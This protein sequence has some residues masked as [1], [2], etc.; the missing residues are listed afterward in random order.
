MAPE[1]TQLALSADGRFVAYATQVADPEHDTSIFIL[2]LADLADGSQRELMRAAWLDQLRRIP[3]ESDWSALLDIGAGVQL[4]RIDRQGG[5]TPLLVHPHPLLVGQADRALPSV[6]H[7]APRRVGVLGYDWS[8]DGHWLWY[9]VLKESD[10]K[11]QVI[12]D[13]AVTALRGR[14]RSRA[15]ATIEFHLRSRNG[16]DRLVMSRPTSD[17]MAFYYG[18]NVSWADDEIRYRIENADLEGRPSFETMVWTMSASQARSVSSQAEDP[19]IWLLRGPRGGQLSTSGFGE[20]RELVETFADGSRYRYGRYGFSI[21]DPRSAGTWLAKGGQAAIVGT[22]TIDHPRYGLAFIERDGVRS[23]ETEGS[24]TKCDFSANLEKGACIQEGLNSPPELV[25]VEARLGHVRRIAPVSP[26]HEEISP[27]RIS[28]RKW[29]NRLGYYATGF[30]I[31]PRDF[32]K[33]KRYPTIVVTHGSDVDERFSNA[34]MQWNYPVQLFAERGYVV[35]L[36]ND[37]AP[38]QSARLSAAYDEWGN[39]KG[40]LGPAEV[41][42]LVWLNGV[43]SFEDAVGEMVAQGIVDPAR[44]GIAGYSRGSQMVNVAMTQSTMFRAASSGDGGFLEPVSYAD[45]QRSYDG[46]F[47][48]SPYGK[49]LEHY[50]Q[51]SPSLRA[52]KVCGAILQQ[53]AGPYAGALDF[54]S[55]LRTASVP[56]Q[57]SLYPGESPASDET[58]IFHIPSNRALAMR[59]NLAWFDF[60]LLGT[61][62]AGMPFPER[63]PD[64]EAASRKFPDHCRDRAAPEVR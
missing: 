52:D 26:R 33:G 22:R 40:P 31:W 63:Y 18:G 30:I 5:V 17:R 8:P 21:G 34:T 61:R 48:G 54:F 37:P 27:L 64:W 1:V 38:S 23:I 47:G 13:Q 55:A 42:R 60:W 20:S 51:L 44:I 53:M 50:L 39:G 43:Y 35:L 2:R 16:D 15:S 41:Q 46:I 12:F 45:A 10:E 3:G 62:D 32:T 6:T 49:N 11:Q 25:A 56:T 58:H 28:P 4:Y 29:V 19:A 14:R 36:I 24:L 57:I 9:S 59:E 7:S